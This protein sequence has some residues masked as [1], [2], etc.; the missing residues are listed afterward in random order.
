VYGRERQ[1]RE[2]DVYSQVPAEHNVLPNSSLLLLDLPMAAL[3][4]SRRRES[5]KGT[6]ASA[7]NMRIR[8]GMSTMTSAPLLERNSQA[9]PDKC[10]SGRRHEDT[11]HNE[12]KQKVRC[13]LCVE[14][15][16][17]SRND[18]LT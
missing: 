7:I 14:G 10:A 3:S 17:F 9:G 12:C 1:R 4:D 6:S 15:K 2:F 18:A 13:A 11:I 8:R 5:W 16:T